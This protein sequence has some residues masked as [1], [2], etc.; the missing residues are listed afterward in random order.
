MDKI[1]SNLR[2]YY[3][4]EAQIRDA[5]PKQSWKVEVREQF[6]TLAKS[7]NKLTLLEL[8]AGAGYDS[9]Y[10]MNNGMEV[11]AID[12]SSEMVERC[13]EKSIEAYELDFYDLSSLGKKFDCVWSMNSL[14][15]VPR[16]DLP[17]VLQ[18]IN[19]VLNP[20]GL[21]Y[22]GVYGG[23]DSEAEYVNDRSAVPRFFSHY[24]DEKLQ[25]LLGGYF[26]IISFDRYDLTS[27]AKNFFKQ[28]KCRGAID[29]QSAVL[30]KK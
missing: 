27:G 10:F 18:G 1:K 19:S 9:Q 6:Y 22:M 12:L 24:T 20:S 2:A 5:S 26:E 3:N 21:F 8:G 29:F 25:E 28:N 7:E 14:L 30:R 11:V 15:H 13:K 23:V 17:Q 4:E 16:P